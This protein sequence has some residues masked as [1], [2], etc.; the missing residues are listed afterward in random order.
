M[1][2]MVLRHA[3]RLPDPQ[4]GLTEAGHERA[5]LLARMLSKSGVTRAYCTKFTRA[6]QTLEPLKAMLGEALT[7]KPG[8]DTD[9]TV[10]EVKSLPGDATIIIVGHSDT[11][12]TIVEALGGGAIAAISPD[13]FDNLFILSRTSISAA[14]MLKLKFGLAT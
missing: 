6:R 10:Q 7:V 3:D 5:R 1:M 4:D 11:V 2:I 8:N 9:E 14:G 13:E 12:P